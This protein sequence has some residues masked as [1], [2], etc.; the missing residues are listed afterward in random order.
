MD[1]ELNTD[2]LRMA[3]EYLLGWKT[4]QDFAEWLASVNWDEGNISDENKE[5]LSKLEILTTEILEEL[6]PEEDLKQEVLEF[7]VRNTSFTETRVSIT[8]TTI[9]SLNPTLSTIPVTLGQSS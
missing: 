9:V 7:L 4:L 6:R 5:V 1:I 2:L 3:N 8:N